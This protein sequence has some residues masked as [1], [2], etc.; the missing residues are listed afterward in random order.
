MSADR[1]RFIALNYLAD[2]TDGLSHL[3]GI[4]T[5]LMQGGQDVLVDI[6][7]AAATYTAILGDCLHLRR[8]PDANHSL[9]RVELAN[10]K[11][12][13]YVTAITNPVNLFPQ[14]MSTDIEDF[15]RSAQCTNPQRK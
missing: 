12:C 3:E 4:P 11:S 1:H 10:C 7:E 8:Y 6:D 9:I 13:L 14:R 15:V 2:A 5:L